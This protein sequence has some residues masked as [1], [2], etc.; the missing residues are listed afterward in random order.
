MFF[1]PESSEY[2]NHSIHL[3]WRLTLDHIPLTVNITI[4]KEHVQTKK[5]TIVKNS[6]KE[7]N[8]IDELIEAIKGLNIENCYN[9][10]VLELI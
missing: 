1:R 6:K 3:D 5:C 2:N 4:F 7:E 8:F 10:K 9:S